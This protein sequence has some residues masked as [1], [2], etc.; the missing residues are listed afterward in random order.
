MRLTYY[1]LPKEIKITQPTC[2]RTNY[3][4]DQTA[5]G[6]KR[7]VDLP[8]LCEFMLIKYAT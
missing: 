7:Q 1:N 6:K 4:G 3:F 2:N 8:T 5:K